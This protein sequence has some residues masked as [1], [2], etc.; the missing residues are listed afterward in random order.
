M[1]WLRDL[2]KKRRRDDR[3]KIIMIFALLGIIMLG[4]TVYR[5][6]K[7]YGIVTE[8]EEYILAENETIK[9]KDLQIDALSKTENVIS[10]SR[11]KEIPLELKVETDSISLN[12]IE[13]SESYLKTVYG[14]N[15][16]S[17]SRAFFINESAYNILM[18]SDGFA[19]ELEKGENCILADYA[20]GE[21]GISCGT[22]KVILVK[23]K[24]PDDMPYAFCKAQSADLGENSSGVRVM[25]ANSDLTSS[26]K[27]RLKDMGF[28][29]A[30]SDKTDIKNLLCENEFLHIKYSVLIIGLCFLFVL[31]VIFK[32]MRING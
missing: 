21:D 14:I 23:G 15:V 26:N 19:E 24:L 16:N 7:L 6:V 10:I 12:C 9:I 8:S 29:I 27:D 13:L 31:S 28:V 3:I 20:L 5:I 22:A 11:Q 18:Q 25:F 4:N 32:F 2:L 30:D 1:K 17:M